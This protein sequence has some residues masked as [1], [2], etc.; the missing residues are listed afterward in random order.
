VTY[1]ENNLWIDLFFTNDDIIYGMVA[2][3]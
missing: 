2:S 1:F 3:L